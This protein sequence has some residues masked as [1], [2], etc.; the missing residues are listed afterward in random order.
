MR[1]HEGNIAT[2][3]TRISN[4][5]AELPQGAVVGNAWLEQRSVSRDLAKHYVRSGWLQRVGVGGYAAS[6]GKPTWQGAIWGLQQ[7]KAPVWPGG[8]TAL[9]MQGYSQNVGFGAGGYG[10]GS[11]G[12]GPQVTLFSEPK[13]Q[14]PAWFKR[15]DWGPEV[16]L[17]RASPFVEDVSDVAWQMVDWQDQQLKVSCPEQ[18]AIELASL[19]RDEHSFEQL[20]HAMESLLTL[21][22]KRMNR[23][24]AACRSVKASRLVLL[25]GEYYKH[26]WTERLDRDQLNLGSGK[27]QLWAGGAMH[28]QY[29]IT[30]SRSLLHG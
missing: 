12:R 11:F 18:A 15:R 7:V 24:L 30:V 19:V 26:P 23:L 20:Q 5:I 4:L 17:H 10:S 2:S 22:P 8:I 14:L 16:S 29:G 13:F 3:M 25:L 28:P 1:A 9:A 6:R 21:R 27:R